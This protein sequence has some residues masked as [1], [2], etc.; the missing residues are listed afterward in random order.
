MRKQ[1]LKNSI[2]IDVEK[3]LMKMIIASL[4]NNWL[5]LLI[6]V[7]SLMRILI[8]YLINQILRM[9]KRESQSGK[10]HRLGKKF[11]INSNILLLFPFFRI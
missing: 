1:V 9:I 10:K 8:R 7:S 2:K 6:R 3:F 5:N 4:R 11:K